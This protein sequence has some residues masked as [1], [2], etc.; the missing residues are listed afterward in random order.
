MDLIANT[1]GA[2]RRAA[3][4]AGVA[5][6]DLDAERRKRLAGNLRRE[7]PISKKPLRT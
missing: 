4:G 7:E 1:R 3:L 2:W 5:L 6:F